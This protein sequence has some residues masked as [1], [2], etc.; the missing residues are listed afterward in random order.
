MCER[1]PEYDAWTC[2]FGGDVEPL[3]S[4][5]TLELAL[6]AL[7]H[8]DGGAVTAGLTF[9]AWAPYTAE[10]NK[11]AIRAALKPHGVRAS[12]APPWNDHP[13]ARP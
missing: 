9:V 8:M 10:E 13:R 12:T 3:G 6:D 1:L 7:G 4:H 5:A 2:F 11:R